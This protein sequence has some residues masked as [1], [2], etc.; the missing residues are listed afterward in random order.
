[1]V[2][3]K[4]QNGSDNSNILSIYVKILLNINCGEDT[5]TIETLI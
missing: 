2:Y 5:C 1:M 3:Q 4:R